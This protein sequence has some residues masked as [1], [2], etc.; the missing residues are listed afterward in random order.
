MV[1]RDQVLV[2]EDESMLRPIRIGKPVADPLHLRRVEHG[3]GRARRRSE[4]V[5]QNEPGV[6]I[7]ERVGEPGKTRVRVE[8]R[9][10]GERLV[11]IRLRTV[12]RIGDKRV[13]R[14]LVV[15]A[16]PSLGKDP[17][18]LNGA[19]LR[20]LVVASE[21]IETDAGV[22]KRLGEGGPDV[23]RLLGSVVRQVADLHHELDPFVD[24]LAVE[25]VD[26]VDRHVGVLAVRGSRPLRIAH[27]AESPRFSTCRCHADEDHEQQ[28]TR[29]SRK[30]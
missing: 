19:R 10:N 27:N 17:L 11:G 15:Q 30:R 24:E 23:Q 3:M 25:M 16:S 6:A 14:G 22:V 1:L 13:E 26:D 2:S 4:L 7:V 12:H 8:V 18:E 5:E 28:R 20:R 9:P 21:R 29:R